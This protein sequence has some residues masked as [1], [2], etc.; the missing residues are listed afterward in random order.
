LIGDFRGNVDTQGSFVAGLAEN[1]QSKGEASDQR[2]RKSQ[3]KIIILH[4]N[5]EALSVHPG[6]L[7]SVDLC[8]LTESDCP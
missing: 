2:D 4:P 7:N 3:K 8:R 1:A 6:K 5:G